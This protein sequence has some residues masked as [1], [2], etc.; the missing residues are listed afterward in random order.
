MAADQVGGGQVVVAGDG[1]EGKLETGGHVGDETGLAATRR[2][3]DE[4]R[5]AL[6]KAC[7]K[8]AISLPEGS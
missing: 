3:L 8:R 6:V 5:Q 2:P 4:Q 7:S 1:V